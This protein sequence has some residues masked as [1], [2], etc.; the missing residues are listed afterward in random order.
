MVKSYG[1]AQVY[2]NKNNKQIT[3]ILKKKSFDDKLLQILNGKRDVKIKLMRSK[4]K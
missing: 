3:L 1:I 4:S 2:N